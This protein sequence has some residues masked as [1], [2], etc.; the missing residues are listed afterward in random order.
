MAGDIP[1]VEVSSG[2]RKF[3]VLEKTA[4]FVAVE[5]LVWLN[6]SAAKNAPELYGS[7][8]IVLS[9]L[10][11]SPSSNKYGA[12]A[13]LAGVAGLGVY[14]LLDAG[15]GR[16]AEKRR[17]WTTFAGIHAVG[18]ITT[19][20]TASTGGKDPRVKPAD[21]EKSAFYIVPGPDSLML[22]LS[23]RF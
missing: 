22:A 7:V 18:I 2:T 1:S 19:A 13:G 15:R 17:F 12:A 23:R 8:L 20:V 16:D 6:A 9:P 14:N 10:S 5:G 21:R 3:T 4:M 11:V